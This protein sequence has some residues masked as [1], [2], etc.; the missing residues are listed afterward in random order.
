MKD[1]I[2]T[3]NAWRTV[4][5]FLTQ[6]GVYEVEV[7]TDTQRVRC[8]CYNFSTRKTC[9]HEKHVGKS[10]RENGGTYP[11]KISS[12]ATEEEAESAQQSAQAFRNFILKYGKVE[13][14]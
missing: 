9:A 7:N 11:V 10:S 3:E 6:Q 13:V 1:R 2:M 5:M 4:Q 12:R 8:N 14:L